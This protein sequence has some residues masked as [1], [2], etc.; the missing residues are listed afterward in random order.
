MKRQRTTAVREIDSREV[1]AKLLEPRVSAPG[2]LDGALVG[3]LA[4]IDANGAPLVEFAGLRGS[5]PIIARTTVAIEGAPTGAQVVLVFEQSRWELPIVVGMLR[6]TAT[7]A[8]RVDEVVGRLDGE[9]LRFRAEREIVLECG[10]ASITLT[11][12]GKVLIR[13]AHLLSRSSGVNRIK[14]GS[15]QL[16]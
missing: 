11:R 5:E 12:A 2:R 4:G 15:V 9:T 10:K 7:S 8:S 1:L 6:E 14:G 13:G 3:T 16:N